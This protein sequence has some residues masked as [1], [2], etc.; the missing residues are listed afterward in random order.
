MPS[1]PNG[2]ERFQLAFSA[3]PG[4]RGISSDPLLS[5]RS[6]V[7]SSLGLSFNPIDH[8]PLPLWFLATGAA[9][10]FPSIANPVGD[11]FN[12][13]ISVETNR[14]TTPG[15]SISLALGYPGRTALS[16]TCVARRLERRAGGLS[17]FEEHCRE[18][19][20]IGIVPYVHLKFWM[21]RIL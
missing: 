1:L 17:V 11:I 6:S 21:A 20:S 10:N 18:C 19:L 9:A 3:Q 15:R 16:G 7:L 12:T 8:I 14:L 5:G 4:N 2:P 13:P